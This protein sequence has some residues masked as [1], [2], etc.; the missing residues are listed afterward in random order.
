MESVRINPVG[1][2]R[3]AQCVNLAMG[4]VRLSGG[5]VIRVSTLSRDAEGRLVWTDTTVGG[6][7]VVVVPAAS[8]YVV[9][10]EG[11]SRSGATR[12]EVRGVSPAGERDRNASS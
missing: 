10:T 7:Q 1:L 5:G 6:Q 11:A 12:T 8:V 2:N 9:A 3:V 4:I